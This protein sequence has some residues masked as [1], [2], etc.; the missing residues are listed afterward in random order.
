VRAGLALLLVG[1][2]PLVAVIVAAKLGLWPDANP[3]PVGPGLL[4]FISGLVATVCL[5]I[6]AVWVWLDLRQ[7]A[8]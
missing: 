6:G 5:A 2:A 4:F 7:P 8:P 3:N 1:A